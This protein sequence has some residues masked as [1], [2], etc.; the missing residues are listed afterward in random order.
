M[1]CWRWRDPRPPW[2]GELQG[3]QPSTQRPTAAEVGPRL[4]GQAALHSTLTRLGS[5]FSSRGRGGGWS[6]Q[7]DCWAELWLTDR[8]VAGG[9]LS[10]LSGLASLALDW[11]EGA[12]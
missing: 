10:A 1:P 12:P 3:G 6:Q 7:G 11:W 9:G 2:P 8:L 4:T 5:Q